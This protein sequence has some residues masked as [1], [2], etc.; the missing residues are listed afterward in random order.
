M[1]IFFNVV[2]VRSYLLRNGFVYTLRKRRKHNG[3]TQAVYGNY[4]KKYFVC[5]VLVEELHVVKRVDQLQP[6]H[7]HSGLT[8]SVSQWL[9]LAKRLSKTDD[10]WLYKVTRMPNIG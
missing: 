9:S 2:A 10:I 3:L 6:Y 4:Y 7:K 1:V 5:N 8:C